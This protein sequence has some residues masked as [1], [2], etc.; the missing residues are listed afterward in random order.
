MILRGARRGQRH[1]RRG[2]QPSPLPHPQH[3]WG[4]A[5]P[6]HPHYPRTDERYPLVC[7]WGLQGDWLQHPRGQP[8]SMHDDHYNV[9]PSSAGTSVDASSQP[10]ARACAAASARRSRSARH[11]RCR[12]GQ[13]RARR[14]LSAANPS[15]QARASSVTHLTSMA[16]GSCALDTA[17]TLRS[18]GRTGTESL[19]LWAGVDGTLPSDAIAMYH[20][21]GPPP[22]PAD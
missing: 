5:A 20:A 21:G 18:C 16:G 6:V 1:G 12:G 4:W 3:P 22:P 13:H 10:P 9:P 7:S 17:R 14:R 15:R 8:P 11:H 19:L 2:T